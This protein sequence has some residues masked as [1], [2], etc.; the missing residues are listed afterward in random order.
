MKTLISLFFHRSCLFLWAGFL[1]FTPLRSQTVLSPQQLHEEFQLIQKAYTSLHP[2]LY[3]YLTE[4]EVSAHFVKLQKQLEQPRDRKELFKIYSEFLAGFRCGHTYCN[5]WNQS[6]DF[7]AEVFFQPD[8]LPFTFRLIEK[9][10]IVAENVSGEKLLHPGAEIQ[11]LNQIPI[12]E[13]IDSLVKYVKGDG[14]KNHKRISDLQVSGIGDYEAFDIFYPLVFPVKD[15]VVVEGKNLLSGEKFRLKVRLLSPEERLKT[16]ET[17]YGKK[18]LTTDE[19]WKFEVLDKNTGYLQLGSFTTWS[20]TMDWK[21]FLQDS[22][23]QLKQQKIPSLIIDIRDNEGGADEVLLALSKYILKT[24]A[25]VPCEKDL[26]SYAVVPSD[27]RPYLST[28]DESIFDMSGKVVPAERGYFTWRKK[29]PCGQTYPASKVA[30]QGNIYL[31]IN[32]GNSSATFF[33]ARIAKENRLA[34]LVGEETGGSLNGITGGM[35]FFLKL[36]HSQIEMDIPLIAGFP[37]KNM[38]DGGV[39]PD[40]LIT[41]DPLDIAR[42]K[43]TCLEAVKNMIAKQFSE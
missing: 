28:W 42:G 40:I 25:K 41:P 43:D 37:E 36:P 2:G 30:Y 4:A 21:K 11:S 1:S 23:N 26:L 19:Q 17:L 6:E 9:R 20:M 15:S 38:P 22:F 5:F 10:M 7:K 33:L 35:M 39:T 31:L 34:T 3:R 18:K 8:K 12:A 16:L 29:Y 13:I 14:F 32:A 27:L 24:P